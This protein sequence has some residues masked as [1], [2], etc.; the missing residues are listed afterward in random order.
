ME[1][2]KKKA[3]A[4]MINTMVTSCL[5]SIATT[6]GALQMIRDQEPILTDEAKHHL[7]LAI[8]HLESANLFIAKFTCDM[9]PGAEGTAKIKK[10]R[11]EM[12]KDVK[13]FKKEMKKPVG[14]KIEVE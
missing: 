9:E 7:Q 11:D 1:E 6:V 3:R 2:K 8:D 5:P 13:K 4:S 10:V 12:E 14:R